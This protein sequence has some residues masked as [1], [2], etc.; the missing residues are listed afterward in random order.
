MYSKGQGHRTYNFVHPWTI[1]AARLGS[2]WYDETIIQLIRN[3]LEMA[4]C[5]A[6][7]SLSSNLLVKYFGSERSQHGMFGLNIVP[8]LLYQ[9]ISLGLE[10][11]KSFVIYLQNSPDPAI[12][13]WPSIRADRIYSDTT[14]TTYRPLNTLED[15]MEALL[16]A[17]AAGNGRGTRQKIVT[18]LVSFLSPKND[19]IRTAHPSR[20]VW[21]TP[22]CP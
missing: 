18:P 19:I 22:T 8:P 4:M 1:Q 10:V 3:V 15:Y 12:R 2:D 6:F 14:P 7:Q 9:G 20:M 17:S 5:K 21:K 11:R 13:M 16:E